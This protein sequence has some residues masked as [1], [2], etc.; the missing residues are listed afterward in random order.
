MMFK[1]TPEGISVRPGF[2]TV[3]RPD[4]AE[5]TKGLSSSVLQTALQAKPQQPVGT[6]KNTQAST[7][8]PAAG[9]RQR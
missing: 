6:G 7:D 3:A 1:K 5:V 9:D 4:A 8:V 2:T